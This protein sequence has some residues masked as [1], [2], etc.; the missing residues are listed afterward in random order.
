MKPGA[1]DFIRVTP[2]PWVA[3]HQHLGYIMLPS[4][5]DR[6]LD[7]KLSSHDSNRDSHMGY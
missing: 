7:W 5:E 6:K 3:G 4:Q 1:G 2:H